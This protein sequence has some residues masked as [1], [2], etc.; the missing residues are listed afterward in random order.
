MLSL[1]HRR[2]DGAR[3]ASLLWEFGPGWRMIS[4]AMVGGG[5]GPG[6]WVLNAQAPVGE[7][8]PSHRGRVLPEQDERPGEAA[9]GRGG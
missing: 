3:L 4:S 9:E 8:L 1:S 6:E 5:I 7:R 2:E